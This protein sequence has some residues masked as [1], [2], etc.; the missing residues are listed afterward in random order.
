MTRKYENGDQPRCGET[1][2][3]IVEG[4]DMSEVND[5]LSKGSIVYRSSGV[6]T[7]ELFQVSEDVGAYLK[8]AEKQND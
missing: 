6:F 4:H 3:T 1:T 2:W 7:M 8:F 5:E